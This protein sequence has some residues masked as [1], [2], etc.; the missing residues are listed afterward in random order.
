MNKRKRLKDRKI[1]DDDPYL[2]KS[3]DH[4]RYL[5]YNQI[6][7]V[8]VGSLSAIENKM[9]RDFPLYPQLRAEILRLGNNEVRKMHQILDSFNVE[10]ASF[11]DEFD[12]QG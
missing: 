1:I 5:L 7:N 2:T 10:A 12:N 3:K 6:K 4:L 8:F 11:V 9:G